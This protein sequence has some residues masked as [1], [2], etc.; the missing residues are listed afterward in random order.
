MTSPE[1]VKQIIDANGGQLVGKTRLQKTAYFLESLG[2]GYGFEFDY[3]YYGPYSEDLS[4]AAEDAVALDIVELEERTSQAGMS[5]AVFHSGS[6]QSTED[7]QAR[8]KQSILAVL[9]KYDATSLELA[10]T[11]D[12]LS[13]TGFA[14]DPWG[15][16]RRRKALKATQDRLERL[17]LCCQNSSSSDL[18]KHTHFIYPFA[19]RSSINSLSIYDASER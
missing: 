5:Y 17:N 12:F 13:K 9:S 1:A 15:E 10:A 7:P 11:V 4:I 14:S 18:H 3:H 2:A 19:L 6:S 8:R 16:T